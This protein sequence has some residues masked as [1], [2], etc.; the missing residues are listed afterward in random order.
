VFP[1]WYELDLYILFG[2]NSVF[3]GLNKILRFI[4]GLLSHLPSRL[5]IGG[6]FCCRTDWLL[7]ILGCEMDKSV[8]FAY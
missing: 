1:V 7:S 4:F 5:D 6:F 2:R 8:V 3:K